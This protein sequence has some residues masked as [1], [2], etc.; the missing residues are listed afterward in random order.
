MEI[1]KAVF[2]QNKKNEIYS[3]LDF[4]K[5]SPG[6]PTTPFL[7]T[8]WREGGHRSFSK[9]SGDPIIPEPTFRVVE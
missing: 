2:P 1:E 6:N 3:W 5:V 7:H 8:E 9:T 4:A